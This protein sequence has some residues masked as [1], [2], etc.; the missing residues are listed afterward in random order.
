MKVRIKFL[1]FEDVTF[2]ELQDAGIDVKALLGAGSGGNGS[3]DGPQQAA[4]LEPAATPA[5]AK[6]H[7]DTP[8]TDDEISEVLAH[9][10]EPRVRD[11]A[12]RFLAKVRSWE[13]VFPCV[14]PARGSVKKY[15]RL[16]VL[17]PVYGAIAYVRPP[18]AVINL[19][20]PAVPA[21]ARLAE[22]RGGTK[23]ISAKNPLKVQIM[24]TSEAA[25]E[26]ALKLVRIAYDAARPEASGKDP[27][28]D[29]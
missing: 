24:L 23:G 3:A 12:D 6:K 16:H 11:L 2:Q 28:T 15:I 9:I 27:A 22:M 1:D 17:G 29:E 5:P 18:R 7:W 25:L 4:L 14:S 26:E 10:H 8:A 13:H 20:L 19:R 21:F